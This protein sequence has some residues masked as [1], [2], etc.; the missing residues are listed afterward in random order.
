MAA[1]SGAPCAIRP[2]DPGD[3]PALADVLAR[4]QPASDYPVQWPLPVPVE[5]F[6]VRGREERAWSALLDER[7]VGHVSVHRVVDDADGM[8]AA[9][10]AATGVGVEALGEVA[11]LFVDVDVRG[12]G[13]G[14]ALLDVA[15][16]HI[17]GDGRVPVLNVVRTHEDVRDYYRRRGWREVGELSIDWLPVPLTLMALLPV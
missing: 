9:W 16:D 12:T 4:Q 13:V 10:A 15:V 3:L 14:G 8:G 1:P 11:V 2:R 17:R 7:V 5:E 6:L